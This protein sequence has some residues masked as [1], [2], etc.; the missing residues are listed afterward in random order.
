MSSDTTKVTLSLSP[1]AYERLKK[2][3]KWLKKPMPTILLN[4][5]ESWLLL[6]PDFE[7]LLEKATEAEKSGGLD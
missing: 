4:P 5:A 6:D 3:S 1:V 2:V 7:A